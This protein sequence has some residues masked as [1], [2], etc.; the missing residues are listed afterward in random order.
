MSHTQKQ[1]IHK[2]IIQETLNFIQ[3]PSVKGQEAEKAPFGKEVRHCL[4]YALDLCKKLGMH[5]VSL[6]HAVGFAEIGEGEH[7]IA[8]PVH[9][10]VV[11]VNE[12]EWTYPPFQGVIVD[13]KIIGRGALDDKG[14]AVAAIFAVHR[15]IEEE[16]DLKNKRVRI[17]FFTDE[18]SG[19]ADVP[20]YFAKEKEPDF[21]FTPDASFPVINAE[22]GILQ[23]ELTIKNTKEWLLDINGG[24]KVNVVPASCNLKLA[25]RMRNY[26]N[27]NPTEDLTRRF[28]GIAAHGSLPEKG[29]NAIVKALSFLAQVEKDMQ[30]EGFFNTLFELFKDVNAQGLNLELEDEL[31]GKLTFNLATVKLLDDSLI[32]EADIRYPVSYKKDQILKALNNLPLDYKEINYNA[33]LF[34]DANSPEIAILLESYESISE[35]KGS[36]ISIGGGTLARAFKNAVAFGPLFPEEAETAHMSN[37]YI[38]VDSLLKAHEIYFDALKNLLERVNW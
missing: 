17:I 37:E 19:W 6:S 2:Q 35:N 3:I 38:L 5:T 12:E 4:E 33:P 15:L 1:N 18:E 9:L 8:I 26:I 27:A 7:E 22:K 30:E 13:D 11:P 31:S 23:F 25:E 32:F 24:T 34:K 36:S 16:I 10:D 14:P 20:F 29:E 28:S 21:A